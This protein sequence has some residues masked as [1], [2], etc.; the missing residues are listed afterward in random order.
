MLFPLS[1]S[2]FLLCIYENNLLILEAVSYLGKTRLLLDFIGLD[3]IGL[4]WINRISPALC[5]MININHFFF[6]FLSFFFPSATSLC[7]C[8]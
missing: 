1:C 8:V 4:D 5:Q 2:F 7:A 3:W 6:F